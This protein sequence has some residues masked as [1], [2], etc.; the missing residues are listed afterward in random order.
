MTNIF[1][2][3]YNG[4][5]KYQ[6]NASDLSK[7]FQRENPLTALSFLIHHQVT[8]GTKPTKLAKPKNIPPILKQHIVLNVA[9]L[10]D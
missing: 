10:K 2:F 9:Q 3:I 1:Q 4:K 7:Y 8:K 5:Y 6:D